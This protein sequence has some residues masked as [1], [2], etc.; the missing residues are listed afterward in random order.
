MA[1]QKK[2]LP[3]VRPYMLSY[4]ARTSL[5]SKLTILE[6]KINEKRKNLRELYDIKK[7]ACANGLKSAT[8]K[9]MCRLKIE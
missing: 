8:K 1:G 7:V 3:E 6:E 5:G 9:N 2:V 4:K